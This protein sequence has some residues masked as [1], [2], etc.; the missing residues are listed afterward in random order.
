VVERFDECVARD[1]DPTWTVRALSLFIRIFIPCLFNAL[2]VP[3]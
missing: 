1:L 2:I 3:I